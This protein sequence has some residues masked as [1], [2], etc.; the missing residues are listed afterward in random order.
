MQQNGSDA[1]FFHEGVVHH[2]YAILGHIRSYISMFKCS[3]D[4][5]QISIKVG[6]WYITMHLKQL[7]LIVSWSQYFITEPVSIYTRY[8]RDIILFPKI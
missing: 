1:I 8:G 2:E 7:L 6:M 5:S 3:H 4:V